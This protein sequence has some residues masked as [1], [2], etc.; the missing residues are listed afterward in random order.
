MGSPLSPVI[1]NFYMEYFEQKA[2][3]TATLKP[4]CW[5][6]YVDDTFTIWPH[7]AEKLSNFLQHLNS[8]NKNIQFTMETEN[9]GKL[10]FLD[11]LIY[12]T[13]DGRL[14]HR[15]YRKPTHTGLYLN[16]RSHHHPTQKQAVISSLVH[17][18][19]RIS[20][21]DH[22]IQELTQ[23]TKT[24]IQNGY[25]K[26]RIDRTIRNIQQKQRPQENDQHESEENERKTTAVLPYVSSISNRIGRVLKRYNIKTIYKPYK[27]LINK[28]R[29]VK[30]NLHFKVPGVYEIKCNCGKVYIGQTGR[31]IETR[32][33]EHQ[34]HCNRGNIEK[35][36]VAEHLN[37]CKE[38]ILFQETQVLHKTNEY[39]DRIIKEAIEIIIHDK[40][41]NKEDG[42]K[43]NPVW[44]ATIEKFKSVT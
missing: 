33:K 4:K 35:S 34:L 27:K 38:P 44:S 39:Y 40:N 25:D 41:F 5:Y 43:L 22:L 32:I 8:I 6:R 21:N 36:A 26:Q 19:I 2:L 3:E 14:G 18:A 15:V 10:P 37:M 9:D 12:K 28:L 1:A 7:G 24:L 30:D 29:P 31:T 13:I 17:R 23:V 42:Y 11:I 16:S 20:D